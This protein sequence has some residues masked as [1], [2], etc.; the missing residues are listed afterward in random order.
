[1]MEAAD[2]GRLNDPALVE[3][4]ELLACP[5]SRRGVGH[6]DMNHAPPMVRHDDED[7]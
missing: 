3:A 5:L 6:I 7:E 2:H 1:M 4:Y